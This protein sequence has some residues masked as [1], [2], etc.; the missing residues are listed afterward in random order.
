MAAQ[1]RDDVERET[2]TTRV[3]E[4]VV[5]GGDEGGFVVVCYSRVHT[6]IEFRPFSHT[7][8][9][10]ARQKPSPTYSGTAHTKQNPLK[11]HNFSQ[12]SLP[13]THT[14]TTQRATFVSGLTPS[15]THTNVYTSHAR[16]LHSSPHK[17][18]QKHDN[19]EIG[20]KEL[21]SVRNERR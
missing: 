13:T 18:T 2:T 14:Q 17:K 15:C 8:H 9:R 3:F 1:E 10:R 19:V 20:R 12:T 21:E 5:C 6:E 16:F 7:E 4:V 11:S